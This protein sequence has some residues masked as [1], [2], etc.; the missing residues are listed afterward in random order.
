MFITPSK[1]AEGKS[2]C[3]DMG[4][5]VKAHEHSGGAGDLP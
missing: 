1:T 2:W 5:W 4:H 3:A